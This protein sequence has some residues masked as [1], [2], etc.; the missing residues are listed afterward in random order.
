[1]TIARKKEIIINILFVALIVLLGY[2]I[3]R[4]FIPYLLPFVIGVL[5]SVLLQ[6]PVR[7]ISQH[8]KIPKD[9]IAVT[10]VLAT[11]LLV[12]ALIVFLGYQ[13]FMQLLDFGKTLPSYIPHISQAFSGVNAKLLTLLEGMP[14]NVTEKIMTMPETAV[15]S[16]ASTLTGSLTSFASTL[17]TGAPLLLIAFIITIVASCFIAKDYTLITKFVRA[18]LEERHWRVL[19]QS[20]DL[21]VTNVFKMLRGYLFLMTL[22]FAEL[23]IGFSIMHYQYAA[24]LAA[25]IAL[26][27]ILPV[28]GTG[29]VLIPWAV[30]RLISGDVL[31]AVGLALLYLIITVVRNILEPRVI[32]KQVGLPPLVTLVS[33]YCGLKLFGVLGMFGFPIL[34]IILNSLQKSGKIRLWKSVPKEADRPDAIS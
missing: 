28:L 5:I 12:C 23:L 6:K 14:P 2:V 13:L 31:G 18:Q 22:T 3:F 24:A 20:K 16:L 26:I 9:V 21:F 8:T 11:Y 30:F 33:M 25:L 32:G 7:K 29:T 15:T 19:V 10:M 34:L 1:M 27:D 17:I 4:F